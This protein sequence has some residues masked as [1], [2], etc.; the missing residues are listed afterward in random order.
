[1]SPE[2]L[3]GNLYKYP[4]DIWAIGI[5]LLECALGRFP[6]DVGEVYLELMTNVINGPSP[7]LPKQK[8]GTYGRFS[9]EFANFIDCC[10]SKDPEK[11]S[12]AE[13]LLLHP[14]FKKHENTRTK[15]QMVAWIA[16]VKSKVAERQNQGKMENLNLKTNTQFGPS[17]GAG[18]GA[19]DDPFDLGYNQTT[20]SG[21]TAAGAGGGQRNNIPRDGGS[22]FQVKEVK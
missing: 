14:W 4:S 11:R 15:A 2:R 1:M 16:D 13:E 21:G 10:L 12:T 3:M 5:V 7:S 8:D 19:R 18:A 17:A 20:T 6:Y 9:K 22:F